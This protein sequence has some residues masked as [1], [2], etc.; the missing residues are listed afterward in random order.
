MIYKNYTIQIIIRVL[1]LLI[2]IA[3]IV[4]GLLYFEYIKA[5]FILLLLFYQVYELIRFI[6]K[7]NY[8]Y[9]RF[10]NA[11]ANKD[12]SASYTTNKRGKSFNKLYQ[13]FDKISTQFRTLNFERELQFQ[14]LKTLIKN[15]DIGIIS[16][17]D[18]DKIHLVNDAFKKVFNCPNLNSNQSIN[19]LDSE[20]ANMI[21]SMKQGESKLFRFQS[22]NQIL[23]LSLNA[24]NYNLKNKIFKLISVKNIHSELDIKEQESYQKIISVLTHEIMN[25]VSPIVSLSS[26]LDQR[27]NNSKNL[28]ELKIESIKEAIHAIHDRSR[29]LLN[30][31]HEYRKL[32]KLPNP[33]F[34]KID[35]RKSFD[36]LKKLYQEDLKKTNIGFE[37]NV[38]RDIQFMYADEGMLEQMLINIYKNAFEATTNEEKP[39]IKTTV[40][41]VDNNSICFQINDNGHGISPDKLSKVFIPFYTDKESGSGIGLS[42]CKQILKL[43]GGKITIDSVAYQFTSVKLYFPQNNQE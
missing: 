25:S 26:T 35:I 32:T 8:E 38:D 14:N 19:K 20:F 11:L 1:L 27:L 41:N 4:I 29:N 17:D 37:I 28:N 23:E 2:V 31:T 40:S 22:A 30:F 13:S 9:I 15:I 10:L 36:K 6:N 5:S 12:Y 21:S 3:A 24:T 16:F 42:L 39:M 18:Q 33:V 7:C 43:H 34:K